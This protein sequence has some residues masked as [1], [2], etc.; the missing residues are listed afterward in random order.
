MAHFL[1]DTTVLIDRP[2][3]AGR[4]GGRP[5]SALDGAHV[6]TSRRSCGGLPPGEE[7][8]AQRLFEGLRVTPVGDGP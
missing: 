4:S 6:S 3:R 2:A 7:E 1:L 8:R 5:R